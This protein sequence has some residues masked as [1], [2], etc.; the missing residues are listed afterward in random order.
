[1]KILN[2]NLIN[3]RKEIE[4]M[5]KGTSTAQESSATS[6]PKTAASVQSLE[7]SSQRL[8]TQ[9]KP[10]EDKPL[11]Q[12][13]PDISVPTQEKIDLPKEVSESVAAP[14]LEEKI[15]TKTETKQPESIAVQPEPRVK[16]DYEKLIGENWLNKIG[17]A[18]LVIG[19]GFFVRYAIDKNWIGEWGRVGIGLLTGGILIGIAHYLRKKFHAFSS[20]LIGG[21]ISTFYY[22]ISIA[23]HDY[24][25]FNQTTAF[26]IMVGITLFSS[27]ISVIYDRKELA[28]IALIG[29]FTSPFMVQNGAGNYIIFFTY[30][31]I[32]NSGILGLSYFKKW[33]VL[34][35]LAVGFTTLFFGAWM[36]TNA[37]LSA[38]QANWAIFF[39]SL[40][41]IQ[42]LIVNLIYNFARKMPFKAYEFVQLTGITALFYG[43]VMYLLPTHDFAISQTGFTVLMS[44][45]FIGL[46]ILG[47]V[48][49]GTDPAFGYLMIGKAISFVTIAAGVSFDGNFMA[50]FWATEAVVLLLIGQKTNLKILK[51]TSMML[52]II[53]L[54]GLI[55]EWAM[56]YYTETERLT[57]F[58]NGTFFTG[59]FVIASFALTFILINRSKDDDKNMLIRSDN[60]KFS[61]GGL[62]FGLT[63]LTFVFELVY[64]LDYL[65]FKVGEALIL[66][67][68]HL[69]I[70]LAGVIITQYRKSNL[71]RQIFFFIGCLATLVFLIVAQQNNF[72]LLYDTLVAPEVSPYYYLHFVLT[73]LVIGLLF[74]LCK[75]SLTIFEDKR[76]INWFLSALSV[77]GL[78]IA[79]VELDLILGYSL[80]PRYGISAVF[81]HT[82]TEGFTILW[83]IYSFI[84]MIFGMKKKNRVMRV[85]ALILF[86]I[87]LIK[88]FIFDIQEISEAGKIVAFISLGIL[89]LVISFMYQKL[90]ALIVGEI[91]D[92]EENQ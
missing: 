14:V 74:M 48:R 11:E 15:E 22:T 84:L 43:G 10:F 70:I 9:V 16:R 39:I 78:V 34:T 26:A 42:F 23:F 92:N 50:L 67:I 58:A 49:K 21:G 44:F 35:K 79:T 90:K 71:A 3:V 18:I 24:Q 59:L 37:P 53:T 13:L 52:N 77:I 64:Q 41:Y 6:K 82:H 60:Y 61:V 85:L 73:G 51:N 81:R 32:L 30:I 75:G 57:P 19:I 38:V 17:I 87:T 27:I 62:L 69:S 76:Q 83:G 29:G 5:R 47:Q 40:F 56:G 54:G 20:V 25:L 89:L 63:Y 65:Y 91:E 31:A 66:W 80:A 12:T 86:S 68:F 36:I 2:S 28:I 88:L 7:V 45:F 4:E 33:A 55:R 46:A 1:M 72:T 8:V